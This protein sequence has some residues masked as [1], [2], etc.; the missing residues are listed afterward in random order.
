MPLQKFLERLILAC[1][2]P[3]VL[4]TASLAIYDVIELEDRGAVAAKATLD[5]LIQH[6]DKGLETRIHGLQLLATSPS[7]DPPGQYAAFYREAQAYREVFDSHVALVD[8][9]IQM[10][11]NTRVPYGD[12]LPPLP[13]STCRAA[14]RAMLAT[15]QP[16]ICGRVLGPIARADSAV[17]LVPV[18][19]QGQPTQFLGV[20]VAHALFQQQLDQMDLPAGWSIALLDGEGQPVARREA[21]SEHPSVWRGLDR[22]WT[23]SSTAAGWSAVLAIDARAYYGPIFKGGAALLI[24]L[25]VTTLVAA[26]GVRRAARQ[27]AGAVASLSRPPGDPLPT[28]S[29]LPSPAIHEITA[30]RQALNELTAAR[31]LA[32]A[33]RLEQE[34][35]GRAKLESALASMTDA[36][37][38]T[39]TQG[40]L[41]DFNEAFLTT[42]RFSSR[43]EC[44]GTLAGHST[45]TDLFMPSGE[46]VP[47]EQWPASRALRGESAVNVEFAL[48]RRGRDDI[49]VNSYS[50]API[51]GHDGGIVGS[52]TSGRDMTE[53]RKVQEAL[54][55]SHRDLRHLVTQMNLVEEYERQRIA[56][57]L[58][59]ELQQSLGVIRID[60]VAIGR[61]CAVDGAGAAALAGQTVALVD[62]AIT[63]VRRIVSDLRPQILD[64]L[65]LSA[66]LESMVRNF[67]DRHGLDATLDILGREAGDGAVAEPPAA[68]AS[69]LY[70]ITQEALNNVRKHAQADFVYVFLDLSSAERIELLINDDGRGLPPSNPAQPVSFGLRGMRERAE[71]LGGTLVLRSDPGQGTTVRAWLPRWPQGDGAVAAGAAPA[72]APGL[73]ARA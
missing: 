38:I 72:P 31:D 13:P 49:W 23:S 44:E 55:R 62:G 6:L 3:L 36:V 33:A 35:L 59:D 63:S 53:I 39:D 43:Q 11:L 2:A 8:A 27:L 19:R 32:Q 65:G 16:A 70:R 34:Q 51:H 14:E 40:R 68:V 12:P 42:H 21:A 50:F 71:A 28:G 60:L 41:T 17:I 25:M 66:A 5:H 22:R 24:G 37:F 45:R 52:V 54:E 4:L 47:L 7:L 15:G 20:P 69:A 73:G 64:E 46:P 29:E 57:E 61:Q 18:L 67:G 10:R 26:G 9:S 58:H 1:M 48:R 56:R 30:A